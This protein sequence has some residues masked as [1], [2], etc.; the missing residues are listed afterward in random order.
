[1]TAIHEYWFDVPGRTGRPEYGRTVV[2]MV[3]GGKSE[4]ATWFSAKPECVHGINWL[5][6]HGGSLY[7]GTYPDYVR[8]DYEAM[9]AE[10][11]GTNWD[12][13]ADLI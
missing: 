7:L 10:N 4:R 8:R 11:G 6:I 1:M 13:W 5:P 12:E 3:W 9:V 2:S